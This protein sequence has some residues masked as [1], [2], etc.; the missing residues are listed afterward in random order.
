MYGDAVFST[1]MLLSLK[2]KLSELVKEVPSFY[3][4]K[5]EVRCQDEIKQKV[6]E[7]VSGAFGGYKINRLDGIKVNMGKHRW[8]LIRPSGTEPV[9]RVFAQSMQRRDAEALA[10]EGVRVIQ[11]IRSAI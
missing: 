5:R 7:K 9:F 2:K 1:L 6:M 10:Q 8:L 3:L 4:I 11:E